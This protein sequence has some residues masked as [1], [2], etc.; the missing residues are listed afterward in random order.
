MGL[1]CETLGVLQELRVIAC[2][3]N[4]GPIVPGG[5][6]LKPEGQERRKPVF[7]RQVIEKGESRPGSGAAWLDDSCDHLL[8]GFAVEQR[9]AFHEA[10]IA[11]SGAQAW[12]GL[13]KGRKSSVK[14]EGCTPAQK[15]KSRKVMVIELLVCLMVRV[16]MIRRLSWAAKWSDS[17]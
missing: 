6:L 10:E 3:D 11:L 9:K 15:R 2:I 12:S 17:M 13:T 7:L 5:V 14:V 1:E 8:G 16:R 4:E